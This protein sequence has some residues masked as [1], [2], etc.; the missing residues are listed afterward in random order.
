MVNYYEVFNLNPNM[1]CEEISNVLF[2]E[3]KKW[4]HRQNANDLQKRQKAEKMIALIEEA[5]MIFSDKQKKEQYD[6]KAYKLLQNS[7]ND[8][9]QKTCYQ[10]TGVPVITDSE[11]IEEIIQNAR[12]LYESLDLKSAAEYCN[13]MIG[14]GADCSALYLYL[15][16]AYWEDDEIMLAI[17]ALKNGIEKYPYD[18]TL[19][20][21]LIMLNLNVINDYPT[22][23]IYLDRAL[24]IDSSDN[25]IL[26]LDILYMF[27]T[28]YVDEAE[29]KIQ[30]HLS[31]N[32]NDLE[33]RKYISEAYITYSDKFFV[34]TGNGGSYIPSQKEYDSILYYRNKAKQIIDT[35]RSQYALNVIEERGRKVFNQDNIKGILCL[36]IFGTLICYPLFPLWAVLAGVLTYYSY[37]PVWMMEKMVLTKER[38]TANS[39]SYY[40]Y[41]VC[42]YI[43]KIFIGCI[44]VAFYILCLFR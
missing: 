12:R 2:Q 27:Y 16:L 8:T 14:A 1:S 26:M 17:N 15:G 6:L 25:Y 3:K 21:N 40:L 42:W 29:Q 23:R 31:M 33:Y 19:Y 10:K 32:P 18:I 43:L 39:I 34:E 28:G 22:S 35:E 13:R 20:Q 30:Q 37:Q 44:K 38:D 4:I 5:A 24:E 9:V 36:I 7:C 11:N 41:L